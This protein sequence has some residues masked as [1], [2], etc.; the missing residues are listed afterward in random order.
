VQIKAT[1]CDFYVCITE[2]D[3]KFNVQYKMY[4]LNVNIDTSK[5]KS[6]SGI[7]DREIVSCEKKVTTQEVKSIYLSN[8]AMQKKGHCL[9]VYDFME[10]KI[11]YVHCMK[12]RSECVIN[13]VTAV[14]MGENKVASKLEYEN[15]NYI[16]TN[17][18]QTHNPSSHRIDSEQAGGRYNYHRAKRL[19]MTTFYN[20]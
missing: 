12:E 5:R 9:Q 10:F 15:S 17:A 6:I 8:R 14:K 7:L 2:T 16:P 3:N 1:K 19:T 13:V 11:V 18:H 4:H 20:F